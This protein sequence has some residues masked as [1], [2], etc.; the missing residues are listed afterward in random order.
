[1]IQGSG[2]LPFIEM[3]EL[4]PAKNRRQPR[5]EARSGVDIC[6]RRERLDRRNQVLTARYYYWTELKRRRFDDVVKILADREF[7]IE[8]RTV[9]N[10]LVETQDFFNR[11]VKEE[12]DGKRLK[13]MFPG[14][15]WD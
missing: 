2:V 3:P 1:M 6:N 12:A 10:V 8:D 5:T 15:D 11:L 13:G 14:F 4:V 7:F 9:S